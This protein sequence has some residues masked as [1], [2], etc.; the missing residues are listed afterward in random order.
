[1]PLHSS[2]PCLPI[3]AFIHTYFLTWVLH[4]HTLHHTHAA[5]HRQPA[6]FSCLPPPSLG[7][8]VSHYAPTTTHTLHTH[9]P[10]TGYFLPHNSHFCP[11]AVYTLF[12]FLFLPHTGHCRAPTT[13]FATTHTHTCCMPLTCDKCISVA[14]FVSDTCSV[15][16][17]W[18]P[19]PPPTHPTPPTH[20]PTHKPW[21]AGLAPHT[22][23]H[24]PHTCTHRVPHHTYPTPHLPTTHT[25]PSPTRYAVD[26]V[27]QHALR[28]QRACA[29][30]GVDTGVE[31]QDVGRA[32][33]AYRV[34]ACAAKHR[35]I[36]LF[37]HSERS[38]C[39]ALPSLVSPLRARYVH[40][41]TL[42]PHATVDFAGGFTALYLPWLPAFLQDQF[43]LGW[44]LNGHYLPPNLH[45][46][47]LYAAIVLYCASFVVFTPT[48]YC[49][50]LGGRSDDWRAPQT[51]ASLFLP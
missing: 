24:T 45:Y 3:G 27:T 48:F 30:P 37:E 39:A 8:L 1:M 21:V 25:T 41:H 11:H 47:L 22:H 19:L 49:R 12:F 31:P 42:S 51:T 28:G 20:L 6:C 26:F 50:S 36:T 16:H 34:R 4:T 46:Q 43:T 14:T 10:H 5:T 29:L 18:F 40:A 44:D 17:G 35:R 38:T 23:T 33:S 7:Q 9:T 15:V 32:N 13:T 2:F